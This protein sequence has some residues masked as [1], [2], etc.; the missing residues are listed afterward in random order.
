MS[1]I[2][3][4]GALQLKKPRTMRALPT[5]LYFPKVLMEA[6]F[7]LSQGFSDARLLGKGAYGQVS[8]VISIYE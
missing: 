6:S 8:K 1:S 5:Y 7:L 4:Y 3:S 2:S